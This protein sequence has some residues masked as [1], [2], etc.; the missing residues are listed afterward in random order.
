[1]TAQIATTRPA[2]PGKAINITLWTLQVVLAVMFAAVGGLKLIP[3]PVTAE[4]F[5]AVGAGAWLQYFTGAAE[6]AGGIGLLI[7][8]LS[9]LAAAGLAVVMFGATV[10]NLFLIGMPMSATVTVPL[11]AVFCL[12][13][14]SRR[15]QTIALLERFRR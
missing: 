9:G 14:W 6:L 15:A 11:C 8:R 4:M 12:I 5:A 1:M 3:D 7:P 10:A 13:A 2:N